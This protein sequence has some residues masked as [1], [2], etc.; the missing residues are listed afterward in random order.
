[1]P[2]RIDY[3]FYDHVDDGD[4]TSARNSMESLQKIVVLNSA[5]KA[6]LQL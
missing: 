3:N 1:M 5:L 6:S 4:L 2:L